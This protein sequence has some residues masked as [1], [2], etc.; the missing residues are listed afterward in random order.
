ME[1]IVDG[2]Y[3]AVAQVGPDSIT[4]RESREDLVNRMAVLSIT[5]GKWRKRQQ[6]MLTRQSTA[7][8]REL[9]Y[10]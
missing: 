1:L 8:P 5:V 2:E 9:H 4:L 7:A 10:Y 3:V 6:I